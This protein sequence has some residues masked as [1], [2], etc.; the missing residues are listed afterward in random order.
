MENVNKENKV[1]EYEIITTKK[2]RQIVKVQFDEK[3]SNDLNET[4]ITPEVF[5]LG[6]LV[7]EKTHSVSNGVV[8]Q[9]PDRFIY[10]IKGDTSKI[11]Y[12]LGRVIPNE[13]MSVLTFSSE[14]DFGKYNRTKLIYLKCPLDE[15]ER[16]WNSSKIKELGSYIVGFKYTELGLGCGLKKPDE[17][18]FDNGFDILK[19]IHNKRKGNGVKVIVL[20]GYDYR[21][22]GKYDYTRFSDYDET[23]YIILVNNTD[24]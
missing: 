11:S 8:N 2:Y 16:L 19:I 1:V 24:Y 6:S 14:F 3:Y 13:T 18:L 15:V 20:D 9:Q 22:D 21:R 10:S 4:K 17:E 5:G 23:K 12:G 7:D